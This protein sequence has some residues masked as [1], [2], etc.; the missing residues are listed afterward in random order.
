MGS[1]GGFKFPINGEL[2]RALRNA[3]LLMHRLILMVCGCVSA[4]RRDV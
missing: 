2:T 1:A 3:S 4:W